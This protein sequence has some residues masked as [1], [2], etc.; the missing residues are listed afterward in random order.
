[1][2]DEA[3]ED[4]EGVL[5]LPGK[6]STWRSHQA[7]VMS[8]IVSAIVSGK[9][10]VVAELPTGS[11]KTMISMAAR[12]VLSA[13]TLYVCTTKSL[14]DQFLADFP[15]AKLIKGRVNYPCGQIRDKFP[16]ITAADC[17][18]KQC[19]L[20]CPYMVAKKEAMR[21]ELTVMNMAYFLSEMQHVGSFGGRQL[22]VIDECDTLE[23][24]LL[25]QVAVTISQNDIDTLELGRPTLK[26]KFEEWRIWAEQAKQIVDKKVVDLKREIAMTTRLDEEEDDWT[27]VPI[28]LIRRKNMLSRVAAKLGFFLKHVDQHWVWERVEPVPGTR[29]PGKWVFK[30]IR[31]DQFGDL[32]F[33]AGENFILMSATILDAF[34]YE[35]NVGL[36]KYREQ[37]L[38]T[39][40]KIGSV[41][42]ASRRPII[43]KKGIDLT[44]SKIEQ[45]LGDLP[46]VVKPILDLY[47]NDKGV[48]H[49]V[50]YRIAQK[51]KHSFPERALTHTSINRRNIIE[52]FKTSSRPIVLV[53]P[54]AD[55]GEDFP[56]D[57]CRFIIIVKL[58]FPYLGDPRVSRRLHSMRDGQRWYTLKTVSKVIQMT[59]RGMRHEEDQCTS[60]ILDSGFKKF[61]LAN[62]SLFPQWWKDALVWDISNEIAEKGGGVIGEKGEE[63]ST[64]GAQAI[65]EAIQRDS[66]T[67]PAIRSNITEWPGER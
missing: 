53:S 27:T 40:L 65:S 34:Q 20:S 61:Y 56:D 25:E 60:Y 22:I 62:K 47:P 59:G 2:L 42:D 43:I 39:S 37:G 13:K 16:D 3:V 48:I 32:I 7:D 4:G 21:A 30:P 8:K 64:Q 17:P 63:E 50:T 67:T 33:E 5:G 45:S 18:A 10:F 24:A 28:A 41:F 11:G 15:H 1:M 49:A 58:P 26:T 38:V 31:V 14:Q 9:R 6:F 51:L 36:A 46:S 55:R 19:I 35:R 52:Q 23:D 57:V 12:Q 29:I 66:I 44:Y 54:S